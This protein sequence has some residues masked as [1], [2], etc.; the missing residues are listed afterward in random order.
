MVGK[1]EALNANEEAGFIYT[2]PLEFYFVSYKAGQESP[3]ACQLSN[4]LCICEDT[5]VADCEA[6]AAC[7][8]I[9]GEVKLK[10]GEGYTSSIYV[11]KISPIK[12]VNKDGSFEVQKVD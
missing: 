9:K 12:L 4:C 11:K 3:K 10:Q 8:I 2:T 7:K 6:V 1:L 5:E